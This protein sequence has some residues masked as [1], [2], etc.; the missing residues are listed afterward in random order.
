M[1][2]TVVAACVS[3]VLLAAAMPAAAQ[4]IANSFEELRLLV[5]P[6]D[7]ITIRSSAGAEV[8]GKIDS[9]SRSSLV[10]R[11]GERREFLEADVTS[12]LQRRGDSLVNGALWGMAAGA[13]FIAVAAAA[14]CEGDCD[15]FVVAAALVYSGLGAAIGIGIDALVMSRYVVYEKARRSVAWRVSPLLTPRRQGVAVTLSFR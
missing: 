2:R 14:S 5:R 8:T 9:L 7:T 15:G 13:G 10:L 11:D 6:G 12:I 1:S 3:G 4:G